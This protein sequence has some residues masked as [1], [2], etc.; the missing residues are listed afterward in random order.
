MFEVV[1]ILHRDPSLNNFFF[2]YGQDG[3]IVGILADW[4]VASSKEDLSALR[5]GVDKAER[6]EDASDVPTSA[7]ADDGETALEDSLDARDETTEQRP[8]YRTGT[9]PFMAL[10]LL[11]TTKIVHRYRHDLESFFYIL[12]YFCAQFRP[13]TPDNPKAHFAYLHGWE[14]GS[15]KQ[16]HTTKYSFLANHE[17][18]FKSLFKVS[19]EEFTPLFKDWIWPLYRNIFQHIPELSTALEISYGKVTLALEEK[20]EEMADLN[21]DQFRSII[22]R[23]DNTVTFKKF[24]EVLSK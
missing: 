18:A 24:S 12:C 8:R 19:D 21:S 16:V 5:D 15:T 1:G 17:G 9:G 3:K 13:F 11:A 22:E 4:D 10:D 6:P 20:D 23:A 7:P 2:Y 14:S